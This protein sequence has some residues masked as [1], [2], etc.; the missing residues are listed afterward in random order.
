MSFSLE[1][2]Y[3]KLLDLGISEEELIE[4]VQ[5]KASQC[6]ISRQGALFLVAKERGIEIEEKEFERYKE[7]FEEEI[8]Y[9]DF[10]V[11]IEMINQEKINDIVLLGR[12]NR[13]FRINTFQRKDSSLGKVGSFLVQDKTGI[14]KVTLWDEQV[15]IM[16]TE[17]FQAGEPI[18][19]IGGYSKK[20]LNENVEVHL[21]KKGK[22]I[23]S[24]EDINPSRLPEPNQLEEHTV[25]DSSSHSQT[26]KIKEMVIKEQFIPTLEAVILKIEELKEINKKDGSKSFL[27]KLYVNDNTASAHLNIW[28]MK[29]VEL[30]KI[31]EEGTF[32]SISNCYS[33]LNSYT[34]QFEL[35]STRKSQF[36]IL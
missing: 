28:G 30:L 17:F 23:L 12:I 9:S 27:L 4:K 8:D 13:I 34:Q 3:Q 36:Q 6:L 7:E 22:V 11:E 29:G 20:G 15:E 24:P 16:E 31:I 35:N 1:E 5:R 25:S 19:I 26:L 21:S 10:A 18:L 32:L 2:I 33:K 14:I